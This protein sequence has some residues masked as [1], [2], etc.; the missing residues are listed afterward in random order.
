MR[1]DQLENIDDQWW[2]I[3]E[4]GFHKTG[5]EHQVP[6][7]PKVWKIIE[8]QKGKDNKYVFVSINRK[9]KE[10]NLLPYLKSGFQKQA[11]AIRNHLED[12]TI[13]FQCFRAT[14][15]T[16]LRELGK[17]HEP[18]Y[19]MNQ[20]LQGISH[21]VYTRSEFKDFKVNMV[22]DWMNFIEDKLNA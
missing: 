11:Y 19:L 17:G 6:L 5:Y 4:E 12:Q 10:G 8:E 13:T 9:D 21:R 15:T 14:L 20:Q 16:K 3:M 22:N 2:W 7:H 18:S 1:W